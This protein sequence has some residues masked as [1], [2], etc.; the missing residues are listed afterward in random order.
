MT[1]REL[2]A[3]LQKF[4]SDAEIFVEDLGTDLIAKV[5]AVTPSDDAPNEEVYLEIDSQ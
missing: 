5:E 3:E 1:V 4:P 2:I